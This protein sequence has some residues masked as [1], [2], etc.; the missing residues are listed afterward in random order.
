MWWRVADAGL[1]DGCS[2][3]RLVQCVK[4][5]VFL[6]CI[7]TDRDPR[8]DNAAKA[9]SA[10]T[11]SEKGAMLN[12]SEILSVGRMYRNFERIKKWY[13]QYPRTNECMD[14]YV[15]SI[16]ENQHLEKSIF[17]CIISENQMADNASDG[18]YEVRRKIKQTERSVRDKM[19]GFKI[20]RA[21]V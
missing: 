14:W 18:L 7:L 2:V 10:V 19:D 15:Q 9:K 8:R 4:E 6:C 13:L 1:K 12:F 21:H 16:V 5:I 17:D 11:H 3:K 20:G